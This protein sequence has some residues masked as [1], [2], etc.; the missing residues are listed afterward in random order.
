MDLVA[1]AERDRHGV[2]QEAIAA[3]GDVVLAGRKPPRKAPGFV[4]EQL[5]LADLDPRA[6]ERTA[7]QAV[8]DRSGETRVLDLVRLGERPRRSREGR[9]QEQDD[10]QGQRA[11]DA[12]ISSLVHFC[13]LSQG[14]HGMDAD[15][16]SAPTAAGPPKRSCRA[17]SGVKSRFGTRPDVSSVAGVRSTPD[18][19]LETT[20]CNR[21]RRWGGAATHRRVGP[22][23][24]A[25]P[26]FRGGKVR[27]ARPAQKGVMPGDPNRC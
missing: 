13:L 6:V 7:G 8:G 3:E 4:G 21:D 17:L 5:E 2:R 24:P 19:K 22:T 26:P 1:G 12:D 15:R 23:G 9:R 14:V 25:E 20:C 10:H 11:E 18:T 27:H 16:T